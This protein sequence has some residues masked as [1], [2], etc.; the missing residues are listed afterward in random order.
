[1]LTS[2]GSQT[3]SSSTSAPP[4]SIRKKRIACDNCHFSKVRCTG[5]MSG[6]Q[7][8]ERGHKT[9]HYSE[10][11]M[12]RIPAG[13]VS[14]RRKPSPQKTVDDDQQHVPPSTGLGDRG[15]SDL[16]VDDSM[17]IW[18]DTTD[19]SQQQQQ[20]QFKSLLDNTG[21]RLDSLDFDPLIS[22]F[23]DIDFSDMDDGDFEVGECPLDLAFPRL[24]DGQ[25][26]R[27]PL[28]TSQNHIQ[29]QHQ[30]PQ[31]QP[32][33]QTTQL[34]NT[35]S[36]ST[37]LSYQDSNCGL[38]QTAD[39]PSSP[40]DDVRHWTTQLEELYRTLQ[41]SPVPLDGML[42]H[43][44]QLLPRIREALRSLH[45]ADVSSSATSLILI[46]ACLSQAVTLFEQCVPS[47]LSARSATGSGDLSLRL[48]EFQVDRKAQQA[49][50][51]HIVSK[52]VL[53]MLYVSKLI[54]QILLRPEW[55]N[56]SKR[57]HD[58]LL[59]DLQGRTVTL[60]YQMK[61]RRGTSRIM[62]S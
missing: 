53:S 34:F 10:S 20:Q 38:G 30:Q 8:C 1:M 12:G 60:V 29:P 56:I 24:A 61:Q 14:K 31:P 49:L 50:Q 2:A 11:N 62:E 58:L 7:R 17:D 19:P 25:S 5:E 37:S 35:L 13:G 44:S 9:C 39:T 33:L 48:G 46:L 47:V 51:M 55:S 26:L 28:R 54:R 40:P 6:C 59:E 22:T 45:S 57:T 27:S 18:D 32:Q 21:S 36:S 52:E 42:H 41:K 43:S 23:D 4:T 15:S 3:L 16:P